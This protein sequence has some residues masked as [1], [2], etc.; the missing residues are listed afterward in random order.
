[1]ARS[2]VSFRINSGVNIAQVRGLVSGL[3]IGGGLGDVRAGNTVRLRDNGTL[4][5]RRAQ[6]ANYG[7]FGASTAPVAKQQ[8]APVTRTFTLHT[9]L[10]DRSLAKVCRLLQGVAVGSLGALR[11]G[12]SI[13]VQLKPGQSKLEQ[14]LRKHGRFS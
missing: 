14:D 2:E 4:G 6:L 7:T 11:P 5:R 1:M 13:T 12:G 10:S 8:E 3:L 9:S